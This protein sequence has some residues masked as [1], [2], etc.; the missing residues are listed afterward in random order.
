[1]Y[2]NW[3]AH[4]E[5]LLIL[6]LYAALHRVFQTRLARGSLRF[7]VSLRRRIGPFRRPEVRLYI[8]EDGEES[9]LHLIHPAAHGVEHELL[10]FEQH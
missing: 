9:F 3:A 10:S 7:E 5:I 1:M 4:L 8:L 2:Q 6:S